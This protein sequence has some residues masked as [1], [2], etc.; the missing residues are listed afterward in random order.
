MDRDLLSLQEEKKEKT[1]SGGF[2]FCFFLQYLIVPGLFFLDGHLE[3]IQK[4]FS[5]P[6]Q[7]YLDQ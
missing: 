3:G 6:V 5:K 7:M 1:V 2:Y 4:Q